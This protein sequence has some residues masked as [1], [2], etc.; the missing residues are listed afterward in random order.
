VFDPRFSGGGFNFSGDVEIANGAFGTTRLSSFN[1]SGTTQ[2]FSGVISG[3]GSYRRTASTAGTG[4]ITIFTGD[5]TYSGG[6]AVNDGVL[7]ACNSTGSAT[8]TGSVNVNTGGA[9]GGNGAISG[10][11]NINA[12]GTLAP[13]ESI[14]VLDTGP[15]SFA[16]ATSTY[17][18]E[19]DADTPAADRT[20]VT[21]AVSLGGAKLALNFVAITV[22]S[23]STP[24]TFVVI[25]NDTNSDAVTG[26]FDPIVNAPEWAQVLVDYAYSGTDSTGYSGDGNDV[27]I[28]L[29]YVPEPASASVLAGMSLLL[30]RRN[31]AK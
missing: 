11:V 8:G 16:D 12:G 20:N 9:L 29:T 25:D 31:R 14:G 23:H 15:L 17:F 24:Q 19:I 26:T 3:T 2:T 6:T 13:G 27:A 18:V 1:T 7:L 10:A 5:N 30:R 22:G 28:T 4:G 21:G